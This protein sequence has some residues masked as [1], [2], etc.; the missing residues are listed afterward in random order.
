MSYNDYVL[1]NDGFAE[2]TLANQGIVTYSKGLK[3]N[4][5]GN[6]TVFVSSLQQDS[7]SGA[8]TI[9]VTSDTQAN[10]KPI[11]ILSPSPG[12]DE[13]TSMLDI[14]A[15]APELPNARMQILLNDQLSK[16]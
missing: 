1:P 13:K 10:L 12:L 15:N 16:E 6:F 7:I 14:I 5:P 4:K 3:L 8:T 9:I 2:F 11:M